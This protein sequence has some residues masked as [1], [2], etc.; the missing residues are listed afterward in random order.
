MKI[1]V[2]LFVLLVLFARTFAQSPDSLIDHS[3]TT[4]KQ[5]SP[6]IKKFILP[7][8]LFTAGAVL[9]QF[10]NP[11][12]YIANHRQ[13]LSRNILKS[14]DYLQYVPAIATIGLDIAGVKS[15]HNLTDKLF[16]VALSSVFDVGVTE[17]LKRLTHRM[18]PDS[19]TSNSF[20]SGHTATAF[21]MAEFMNQ[22]YGMRSPWYSIA[23]YTIAGATGALR[24]YKNRHWLSDVVAG[25]GVGIGVTRLAYTIYPELKKIFVKQKNGY[26]F[27]YLPYYARGGGGI[28]LSIRHLN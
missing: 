5:K 27:V 2:I 15:R 6:G 4:L 23:G 13:T 24:I 10:K 21:V 28:M 3:V 19:S 16:L 9:T 11:D 14:D 8:A 7:V 22:E 25:T 1:L 18:R 17:S 26:S 20:S 12:T